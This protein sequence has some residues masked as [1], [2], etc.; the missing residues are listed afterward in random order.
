MANPK[1]TFCDS[2]HTQK[3][4]RYKDMQ[5]YRCMSCRKRFLFGEY[6]GDFSYI[7]HFNTKIKQSNHNVLTRENYCTPCRDVDYKTKKILE[8]VRAFFERTDRY[9]LLIPISYHNI[10][11]KVFSDYEHFTEEYVTK[12]YEDCM[13]NFDLNMAYFEALD[14][15]KF[16][17]HLTSFV[18][19]N[20]FKEIT[21]LQDVAGIS[22]IY[23][24]VLDKYKQVYI[25]KSESSKGM[26]SRILSHWSRKKE[27]S[28]LIF[29]DVENSILPIDVFGA[30]DTTR[31]FVREYRWSQDLD[32]AERNLV[33]KF[34]A[35]YRLN[36]VAGGLNAE[37]DSA[38]RTLKLLN[39]IQVRNLTNNSN[40]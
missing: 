19:K 4:G 11:N 17:R 31:I 1:C 36:R 18:K 3:D 10:P 20:R 12:H 34:D 7:T 25:G 6:E 15:A 14:F 33:E 9:P 27:F 24:L 26:K 30:L 21:D 13:R 32:E 16:G 29:G 23:I 38:L 40:E 2:E 8:E 22:G 5:R 39:T 28:R 35:R 37:D